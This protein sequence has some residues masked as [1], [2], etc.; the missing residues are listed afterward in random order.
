VKLNKKSLL[1]LIIQ[2]VKQENQEV[3][4]QTLIHPEEDQDLN[5]VVDTLLEEEITEV[6]HPHP[7]QITLTQMVTLIIIIII[8]MD[9]QTDTLTQM[10]TIPE[11]LV[12]LPLL[13]LGQID[14]Q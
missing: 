10:E 11:I 5:K 9:T 13:L 7:L 3:V 1:G 6:H 14:F 2:L 12:A 4:I 8:Q